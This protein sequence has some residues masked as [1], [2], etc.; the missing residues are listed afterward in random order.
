[1]FHYLEVR[2]LRTCE[3]CGKA[4]QDTR[5]FCIR[6]GASLLKPIKEK[7][8]PT[9]APEAAQPKAAA[10][11]ATPKKPLSPTTDD[12]WVKPSEVS[13]DRVRTAG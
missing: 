4:N 11:Q 7:P 5:K 3:K 13:R 12:T 8:A 9:P 2:L 6:C 10:P 1:M